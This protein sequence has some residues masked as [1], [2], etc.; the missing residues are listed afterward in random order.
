MG[1]GKRIAVVGGGPAG[2]L[3]AER[4][5]RAGRDVVLFDEKLAWE[6]PCGGGLTYKA[7]THFPF[8]ADAGVEHRV[9]DGCELISARGRKVYLP[10]DRPLAIYSR[11]VL[12]GTLLGRAQAAGT[13]VVADRVVDV[14]GA[15][16]DWRLRTRGGMVEAAYVVLAAGARTPLRTRFSQPF[17]PAD[18][19]QTVGYFLPGTS[20]TIQVKFVAGLEGYI[21]LFP[22][23]D[24]YSAGIC[25]KMDRH[26]T[27]ELRRLL[28]DFL[29]AEGLDHRGA[30]FYAHILP[31]LRRRSFAAPVAG[32][33]WALVGDAA[34]FVDPVTGEGLYYALRSAEL[35]SDCLL[36][37]R[38]EQ[39]PARVA[40]DFL[41]DL[42]TATRYSSLFFHGKFLGGET[43]ERMVQ[44]AAYSSLFRRV[45]GDLFAGTQGY[46]GLK[47]R[48][49]RNLLPT[50]L[51]MAAVRL[52]SRPQAA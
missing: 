14:E 19:M 10:L 37:G 23:C 11:R 44:F 47:S 35:L 3:A 38:P 28:E 8:L 34:G 29:R 41:P 2:S 49:Y 18:V 21:W 25:G 31:S 48:L 16:G 36:A 50:L 27:A 20:R 15:A 5:A 46:V 51:E 9:V 6:K 1:A 39:Y 26:T 22:R 52:W 42:V 40:G 45:L 17:S 43:I 30:P 24:H 12:N 32:D 13:E 4:L 33:G 7:L